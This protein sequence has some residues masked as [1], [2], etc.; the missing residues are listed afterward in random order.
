MCF[1]LVRQYDKNVGMCLIKMYI[2]RSLAHTCYRFLKVW[3]NSCKNRNYTMSFTRVLSSDTR[4]C[5]V[6]HCFYMSH[7]RASMPSI[8]CSARFTIAFGVLKHRSPLAKGS[9]SWGCMPDFLC[10]P[11]GS[12][13]FRAKSKGSDNLTSTGPHLS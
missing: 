6:R 7:F 3:D 10:S 8:I 4:A 9:I 13:S 2:T 11:T 12:T 1:L 5:R